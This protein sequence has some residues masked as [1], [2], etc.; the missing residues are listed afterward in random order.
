MNG[1][2]RQSSNGFDRRLGSAYT[3]RP[4]GTGRGAWAFLLALLMAPTWALADGEQQQETKAERDDAKTRSQAAND[5]GLG[6]AASISIDKKKENALTMLGEM[7]AGVTRGSD[8]LVEARKRNDMLQ[9]NCV[10]GKLVQMKGLLKVGNQSQGEMLDAHTKN[11]E[12]EVNHA[13]T[14][15]VLAHRTTNRLRIEAE[16]CVGEQSIFSGDTEVEV[17]IDPNIPTVDPTQPVM[18][19][20][21]PDVPT[22]ASGS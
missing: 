18:P 21:G 8:L 20:P 19:P 5:Q 12:D 15:L 17:E 2:L 14:K 10:N 4:M 13:Y 9:I 1:I 7:Q 16:Q 22:V 11:L 3:T 6:D